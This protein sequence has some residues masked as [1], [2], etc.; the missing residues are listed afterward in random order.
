[1][2]PSIILAGFLLVASFSLRADD[3][4]KYKP[5]SRAPA[6]VDISL[7]EYGASALAPEA[8]GIGDKAPDFSLQI[9]PDGD[10][11]NLSAV[12]ADG[13]VAIIFYRG[14]W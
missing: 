6:P 2:N 1:M 4:P 10:L 5:S 11:L 12:A 14:H 9:A 8:L 3:A 13:P 7:N